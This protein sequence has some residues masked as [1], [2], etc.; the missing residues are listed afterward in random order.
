MKRQVAELQ[1]QQKETEEKLGKVH[2]LAA[3][4]VAQKAAEAKANV[5]E[6]RKQFDAAKANWEQVPDLVCCPC[7]LDPPAVS[8]E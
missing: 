6:A 5:E 8:G 7:V 1:N 2:E 4:E 3:A